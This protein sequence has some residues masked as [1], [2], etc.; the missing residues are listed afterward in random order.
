MI[1]RGR[2]K[3]VVGG[4]LVGLVP[5][6]GEGGSCSKSCARTLSPRT[7]VNHIHHC[8]WRMTSPVTSEVEPKTI[9]MGHEISSF[10]AP[11]VSSF[12]YCSRLGYHLKVFVI[13][14][15]KL[16]LITLYCPKISPKFV[17]SASRTVPISTCTVQKSSRTVP[18]STRTYPQFN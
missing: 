14:L 2:S 10:H 17:E 8:G 4:R 15:V 12:L 18:I 13:H 11:V 3:S 6:L 9:F 7:G 16:E 5:T 1:P